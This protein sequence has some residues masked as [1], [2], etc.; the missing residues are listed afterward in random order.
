VTKLLWIA[1]LA[2]L[3]IGALAFLTR[4]PRDPSQARK[5]DFRTLQKAPL[6]RI[7]AEIRAGRKIEAIKLMRESTGAGLTEAKQAV[8]QLEKS[9]PLFEKLG[10]DDPET[11]S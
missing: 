10:I 6:D 11:P 7:A 3:V 5:L 2:A 8:D 1:I 9:L 4:R